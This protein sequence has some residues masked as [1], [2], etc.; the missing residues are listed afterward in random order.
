MTQHLHGKQSR[1]LHYFFN[2]K[3][4]RL[5]ALGWRTPHTYPWRLSCG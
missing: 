3:V 5:V 1:T 2:A 4:S